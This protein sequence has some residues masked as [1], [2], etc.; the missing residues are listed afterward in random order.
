MYEKLETFM[1]DVE[2][3]LDNNV[4]TEDELI[5]VFKTAIKAKLLQRVIIKYLPLL[6]S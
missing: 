5:E 4:L 3:L 1:S 6:S 2:D